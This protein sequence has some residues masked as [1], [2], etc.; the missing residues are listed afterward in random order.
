VATYECFDVDVTDSI[1]HVVLKRGDELNTMTPAF[2]RELPEIV[3]GISDDGSARV[4]VI[5]S[6]GRHFSAGMDLAVFQGDGLGG[7]G[8]DVEVGRQRANLR[9]TATALQGSF[10]ALE[11]ARMPVLAAVQGGCIGGAIDMITAADCRYATADAFFCIQEINIGMT[12]DVGTLQRLPK[13]IPEGVARE[14]AYTGDRIP[15]ARAHEVGLVNEVF[16]THDDLLAG[17]MDIAGRIAKQSPLAIWGTKEMVTYTR[18]HSTADSL[19]YIATWQTGMFQPADMM[20]AFAAKAE[21]RD[22]EFQD[23][24]PVPRR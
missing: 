1:A 16:D 18:D 22:P 23:L 11:Q 17:V 15:A 10:T 12:A 6:T 13:I 9:L 3:T 2:W 19:N 14:W 7:G 20:E 8:G 4:I 24:P 5:S 21:K